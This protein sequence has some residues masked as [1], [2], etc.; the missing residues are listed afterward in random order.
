MRRFLYF[1]YGLALDSK[2]LRGGGVLSSKVRSLLLGGG[3]EET[4]PI[5]IRARRKTTYLGGERLC[6]L[7]GAKLLGG[8]K[9]KN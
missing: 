9:I 7:R 1:G 6:V 4:P 8:L 3:H 5:P 2:H